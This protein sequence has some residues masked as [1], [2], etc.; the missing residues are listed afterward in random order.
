M[1]DYG[2]DRAIDILTNLR[3]A[4]KPGYSRV[5]SNEWIIPE[6]KASRFMTIEDMNMMA[7][8]GVTERTE[9]QHK[10]ILEAAGLKVSEIYYAN[11][12]FS[13]SVIEERVAPNEPPFSFNL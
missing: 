5:L 2:F 12:S 8:A 10:E 1:H 9:K 6:Q 3:K 13:E 11:D 7:I 4:M